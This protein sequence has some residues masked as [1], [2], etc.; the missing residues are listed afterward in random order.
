MISVTVTEVFASHRR[1][2]RLELNVFFRARLRESHAESG[3]SR[4]ISGVSVLS[5]TYE[6]EYLHVQGFRFARIYRRRMRE[7]LA[8]AEN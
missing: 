1:V 4:G 5:C 8:P 7:S 6:H 2:F 3:W